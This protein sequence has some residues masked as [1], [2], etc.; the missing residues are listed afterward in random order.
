MK[1]YVYK[2]EKG[3]LVLKPGVKIEEYLEKNPTAIRIS[4]PPS[5]EELKEMM[6]DGVCECVDGCGGIEPDGYCVHGYPSWLI[7]LGYI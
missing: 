4:E 7:A 2:Q 1:E 5:Q 6:D 3:V